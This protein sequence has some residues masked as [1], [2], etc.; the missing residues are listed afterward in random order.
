MIITD[1]N[2]LRMKCEDVRPDE[3]DD[4]RTEL[5]SELRASAARGQPGL[6]LACPQIGIPKRMA[7]VRLVNGI[8]VD[9]VG[10]KIEHSYDLHVFEGEGCLSFP[11]RFENTM[12][13]DEIYVVDNR[14]EPRR[15]I[16]TG[17]L[18]VVIQHELDHL[19]GV[20]LPDVAIGT[21]ERMT[22]PDLPSNVLVNTGKF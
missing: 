12:R 2:A 1:E 13:Y 14:V 5:E 20:L 8:H 16:A 11:G 4:L 6:G 9:L 7:I 10:C 21:A 19:E 15:F 17:L 22:V 18:A 3:I